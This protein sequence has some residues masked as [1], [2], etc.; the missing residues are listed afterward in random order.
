MTCGLKTKEGLR[1]GTGVKR[2]YGFEVS[3]LME[4]EGMD[5]V[6]EIWN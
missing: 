1:V 6:M 5:S 4:K 2:A 3:K